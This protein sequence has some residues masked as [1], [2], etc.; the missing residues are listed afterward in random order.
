M[1]EL[2]PEAEPLPDFGDVS[3]MR[4]RVAEI[5]LPPNRTTVAR[6][7]EKF[8]ILYNPG[9]GYSGPWDNAAIPYGVEPQNILTSREFEGMVFVGPAQSTK[10]DFSILNWVAHS[11]TCDPA[12]MLIVEKSDR[13]ARDFS[14]RRLAR[15]VEHSSA[16]KARLN[17]DNI[18]DKTFRGMMISLGGPTINTLSGKPIPRVALTDYDRLPE[19]VEGEGAPFD[20]ART[21]TRTFGSAGMTVAESSPGRLVPSSKWK[22]RTPHEA[23]PATGILALYNRGDRRRWYWPCPSCGDFFE[24]SFKLLQTD[25]DLSPVQAARKVVMICPENGCVIEPRH[26]RA[27]NG[28]GLWV[29][30]G[31]SVSASGKLKGRARVS[32]IA[33]FWL[34]GTAAAFSTWPELMEKFLVAK[35]DYETTGEETAIKA[36]VNVDQAEP[37]LPVAAQFE[38]SVEVEDLVSRVEP[39]ALETVPA[40]ARFLTAAVDVQGNRFE[41]LVRAWGEHRDSW[42]VDFFTIFQTVTPDGDERLLDPAVYPEDWRL[43]ISRV[44]NRTYKIAGDAEGRAMA[45]ARMA[46][47]TGGAKGVTQLAYDFFSL[48]RRRKI[49]KR[50][51]LVKGASAKGAPRAVERL[52]DSKRR[53]RKA[54]ARG[55]VPVWFFNPNTLKDELDGQLRRTEPAG[56]L[57][58]FSAGLCSETPPH[59]FFEQLTAESRRADGRWIK[60]KPRN[61]AT[62]LMVMAHLGAIQLGMDRIN[63]AR[64]PKWAA[65][66]DAGNPSVVAG[67]TDLDKSAPARPRRRV[68]SR[69]I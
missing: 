4:R 8:R 47:D 69:G 31:Q 36:T 65:P 61:E 48:C 19:D 3:A 33:S 50:V 43:L 23:P 18:F 68:R 60:I 5:L 59:P 66:I 17:E 67:E 62:D 13:D 39:Y 44:L 27:M 37:Y 30:D 1:L 51:V 45:I 58:H 32:S 40:E 12:D 57:V 14:R 63:W 56:G 6:A 35:A 38:Q 24:G 2:L 16:I 28:A 64:P 53:D 52:P 10:T 20:L 26:Q 22:A 55:A 29:G 54:K 41:V 7:A 25:K 9:G 11:V 42:I 46:I 21:R 49:S 34:K 15:M